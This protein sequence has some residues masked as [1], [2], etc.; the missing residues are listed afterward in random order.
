MAAGYI[1][2]CSNATEDECLQKNLFGGKKQYQSQT[3][4]VKVGDVLLLYNYQ[5]QRLHGE[6][7]AISD[8]DFN[9]EPE[10]WS[11]RYPWQVRVKRTENYKFLYK[12]DFTDLIPLRRGL[13]I[14]K[15]SP[16]RILLLEEL[17]KS[18]QRLPHQEEDYR[19]T[20]PPKEW[21]KDG[22]RVRSLSEVTIDNWLYANKIVHGY[23]VVVEE[24]QEIMFCDFVIPYSEYNLYIEFW[25]M[26]DNQY[27]E[28]RKNKLENYQKYNLKLIELIPQDLDS[29]DLVLKEK[30]SRYGI[31]I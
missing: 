31:K 27:K 12:E 8:S 9:I 26:K 4:Q 25:G 24:S 17:F 20:N 18:E 23:E 2:L 13:P 30:L 21:T 5:A 16:E 6:F 3:K 19:D 15:L 22:H 28:R 29:I 7:V 10:A 1:F 11:G 14:A